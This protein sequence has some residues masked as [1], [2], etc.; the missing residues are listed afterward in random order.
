M[1]TTLEKLQE[2]ELRLKNSTSQ[3]NKNDLMKYKKRLIKKLKKERKE[4]GVIQCT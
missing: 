2:V 1:E 4:R 3:K